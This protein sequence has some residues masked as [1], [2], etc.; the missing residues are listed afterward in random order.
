M[1]EYT[2]SYTVMH[3]HINEDASTFNHNVNI[4]LT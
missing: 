3:V 1:H 4:Q 2:D